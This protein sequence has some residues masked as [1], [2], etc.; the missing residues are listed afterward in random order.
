MNSLMGRKPA[1]PDT[2]MHL[3]C[4]VVVVIRLLPGFNWLGESHNQTINLSLLM[5]LS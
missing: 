2:M 5:R 1:N 4:F 3:W